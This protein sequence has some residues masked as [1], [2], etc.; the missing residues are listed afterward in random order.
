MSPPLGPWPQQRVQRHT[1]EQ[2]IGTLVPVQILDVSVPQSVDQLVDVPKIID[3]PSPV[4]Q[5]IDVPKDFLAGQN[6]ADLK[7]LK[8]EKLKNL[9][10]LKNVSL[11]FK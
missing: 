2:I 10:K 5:V 11:M 9:K 4:E 7:K 3:T 6:P 1:V 8:N